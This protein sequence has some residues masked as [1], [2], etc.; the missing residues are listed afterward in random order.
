M[1]GPFFDVQKRFERTTVFTPLGIRFWDPVR[2]TQVSDNLTI[3][4]RSETVYSSVT[5]AFPTTSGVYAFQGLPGLYAI[6]HP[7]GDLVRATSPPNPKSFIIEVKDQQR[8]FLPVVFSVDLPLPYKGILSFTAENS[9]PGDSLPRVYLF[10]APTRPV[11]P[12]MAVVRGCLVEYATQRPAAHVMLEIQV[13]G[14]KWYGLADER[15]CVAVLFPY[16]TIV[17]L[18]G[19]S[20][21]D[22]TRVPLYEQRWELTMR[23]HY[24]PAVLEPPGAEIPYLDSICKQRKQIPAV[25]YPTRIGSA[26]TPVTEWTVDLVFGQELILRTDDL[27]ELWIDTTVSSP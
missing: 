16:P 9:P 10:S 24:A 5:T 14:K 11:S 6:E 27:P 2:D 15:G 22:T 20:L 18:L 1:I 12:G 25:M 21:P 8:R 26:P 7:V 23:V 19:A 13:E 3:T 17:S 4:A